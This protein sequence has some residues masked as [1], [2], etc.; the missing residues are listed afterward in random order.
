MPSWRKITQRLT[1]PVFYRKHGIRLLRRCRPPRSPRSVSVEDILGG[2]GPLLVVTAHP[3]DEFFASGLI[4]EA[5]SR[6]LPVEILCL[7]RG[8]GGP[9]GNG[10][11]EELGRRRETELRRAASAFG[12]KRVTFLGQVDPMGREF[13]TYAPAISKSELSRQLLSLFLDRKPS[14]I[15]THGSDGE[16]WHPAHLLLHGATMHA[17]AGSIPLATFHAWQENHPLPKML[18]RDDP[19]DLVLD[20]SAHRDR[21]LASLRAHESQ[22]EFFANL[23]N[24]SLD[25]FVSMTEREAYRFY[26]VTT[27][28]PAPDRDSRTI[29]AN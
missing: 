29:P 14:L 8:E 22:S 20:G 25:R 18:N 19:A 16:Y 2:P 17:S 7:T 11:R 6:Q 4:C 26:P 28:R 13:R 10:T 1:D 21:R 27:P 24:G 9:V 5:V 3:D 15:V 23:G 12:V